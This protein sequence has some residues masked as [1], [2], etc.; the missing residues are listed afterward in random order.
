MPSAHGLPRTQHQ[1][2]GA[3]LVSAVSEI[4]DKNISLTRFQ[5]LGFDYKIT[6]HSTPL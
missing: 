2:S 4:N 6:C 1:Y 5:K 3:Q